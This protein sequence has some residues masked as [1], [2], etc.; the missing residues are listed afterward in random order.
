MSNIGL[1]IEERSRDIGD[2]LVGRLIPFRKKRMIGPFIFIDHMG[3]TELGPIKYMDV[4]QH[5]HIG[6]S[7]LTYMLEGE[8]MHEDSIGSK[9]LIQPGSVNWMTAGKGVSHTERT[10]EQ[11]KNGKKFTA[12][13]YQIWVALPKHLEEVEPSFQ[14]IPAE[15]LPRWQEGS[16]AFT[17]VAGNGYGRTSPVPVHSELFMVEI[18]SD[19]VYELNIN[20]ELKGE[21]GICVVE[22]AIQACGEEVE[23]GNILVSKVEDT[24]TITLKPNTH[25]LLFGG[26]PFPEERHIY[27]NFVASSKE[28]I[29]AA[30]EAWT[31]KTFPMMPDDT[32]YVPLPKSR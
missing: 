24:C 19:A 22:G 15:E 10:P 2:F 11:L 17:L 29:E 26:I 13:G 32:S 8:I 3:P 16:A 14:H 23:K 30:K 7:T 25:L 27:W 6:L 20:G 9:Q 21:I 1:I 5:P 18:K 12:H 31:N 4:D 28:R